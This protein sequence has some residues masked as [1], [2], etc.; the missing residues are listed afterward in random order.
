[1][2]TILKIN[3]EEHLYLFNI[4]TLVDELKKKYFDNDDNDYFAKKLLPKVSRYDIEKEVLR[5]NFDILELFSREDVVNLL[6]NLENGIFR[7]FVQDTETSAFLDV[8]DFSALSKDEKKRLVCG[9][10][11]ENDLITVDTLIEIIKE[12]LS[13]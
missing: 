13:K 3:L 1:M 8:I 2:S 6:N 7:E 5:R 4:K 10:F 12:N 9:I 11:G